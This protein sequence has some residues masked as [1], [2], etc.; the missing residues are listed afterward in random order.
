MPGVVAHG[1][2]SAH[3]VEFGLK[4]GMEFQTV[5]RRF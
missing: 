1:C 2:S 5:I 3:L 4:G